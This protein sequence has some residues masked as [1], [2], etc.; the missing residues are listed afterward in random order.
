MINLRP[1]T[2]EDADLMVDLVDMAGDGLPLATWAAVSGLAG[3][4]GMEAARAYGVAH[5]RRDRGGFTWRNTIIAEWDGVVAGML[6]CWPLPLEP[7]KLDG[8]PPVVVPIQRLENLARGRLLVNALAVRAEYRRMGI[9]WMLIQTV[10]DR[11][12]LIVGDGNGPARALYD[13]LGFVEVAREVAVGDAHWTPP[14]DHW[15]LMVR[16]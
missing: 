2:P 9:G 13:R 6:M 14:Y 4:E 16:G 5:A 15:C 7:R 12:A 1:A 11:A 8:L 10:T 3:G